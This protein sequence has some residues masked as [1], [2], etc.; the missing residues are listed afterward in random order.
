M[1][2]PY[3]DFEMK[4][5]LDARMNHGRWIVDC[6]QEGCHG[7]DLVRPGE[8]FVCSD[9]YIEAAL[10]EGGAVGATARARAMALAR[11]EVYGVQLPAEKAAIEAALRARPLEH[12]NW[13]PGETLDLLRQENAA[14]GVA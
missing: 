11:G 2:L 12:M 13:Q 10:A 1:K 4:K 3:W 7:A 8:D 14:H 9:C 5:I 6:P